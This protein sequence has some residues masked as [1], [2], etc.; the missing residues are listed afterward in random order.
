MLQ[1][2]EFR[3]QT[4]HHRHVV[5]VAEAL[6]GDEDPGLGQAHR[7]AHFV[8]PE[9]HRQRSDDR[10][11][12]RTRQVRDDQLDDVRQLHHDD[13]VFAD[14]RVQERLRQP[15]RGRLELGI[16][17]A[18]RLARRQGGA[19]GRVHDGQDVRRPLRGV[20]EEVDE[21]SLAPPTACGVRGDTFG[22]LEDHGPSCVDRRVRSDG[23]RVV[24][25]TIGGRASGGNGGRRPRRRWGVR[26]RAGRRSR[27]AGRA[28][29][30]ATASSAPCRATSRP[31]ASSRWLSPGRRVR[32][33][34]RTRRR[35]ARA[36]R[37]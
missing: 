2:G 36:G 24:P 23:Y 34:S 10:A 9:L 32:P 16:R 11:E 33:R 5:V 14:A 8:T 18:Q 17:Q 12:A 13:I 4:S 25:A 29:R 3:L 30:R 35:P 28:P 6:R 21:R 20:E 15:I 26:R 37:A 22:C 19:V 1:A 27:R 31:C 7:L